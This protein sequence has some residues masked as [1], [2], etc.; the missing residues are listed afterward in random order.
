MNVANETSATRVRNN[1][2]FAL[3]MLVIF[4]LIF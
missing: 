3:I 4:M 1:L 2:N